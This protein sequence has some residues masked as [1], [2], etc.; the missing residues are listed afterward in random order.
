MLQP[1]AVSTDL[2]PMHHLT[3]E[4]LVDYASGALTEASATLVASHLVL[5]PACRRE[6]AGIEALGGALLDE[7]P[8][9]ALSAQAFDAVMRKLD[10]PAATEPPTGADIPGLPRP[11]ARHVGKPIEALAWR[12]MLPGLL[13]FPLPLQGAAKSYLLRIKPGRAMPRHSHGGNEMTL[14]LRGS[15]TDRLGEFRPGDVAIVDAAIDHRPVAGHD[16]DCICLA[17]TEAPLVLTGPVGRLFRPFV[18]F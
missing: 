17:V 16:G 14:V 4:L 6:L 2:R 12:R 9:A 11:L 3:Q 13:Y 5:C 15:Y 18:R 8:P 7:A 10:E 1:N